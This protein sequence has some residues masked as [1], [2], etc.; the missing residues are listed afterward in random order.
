MLGW[1]PRGLDFPEAFFMCPAK[2]SASGCFPVFQRLEL[3]DN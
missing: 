2:F 3:Q 1:S